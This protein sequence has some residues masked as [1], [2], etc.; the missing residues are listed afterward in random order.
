VSAGT[1]APVFIVGT[2]RSGTTLTAKILGRHSRLF[3]PGETHFFDDVYARASELGDPAGQ[4]ARLAIA[5]RLHTIYDRFYE[6]EDQQRIARLFPTV[7]DLAAALEGCTGYGAV[8]ERFMR[9]QMQA[10]GRQ[11]WGNNAPRDL[12]SVRD[13][14]TFFPDAR[15]VICVRDVR[16]FL[17]SYQGK[18]KVTG[19]AHVERLKKL[20]H[21]VVTSYL[22]KSS[23]QQLPLL[24]TLVPADERI[25]VRYEDLVTEP[26]RTVRNICAVIGEEFEPGMLEIEGHNSSSAAQTSGIFSS[27]VERW[28]TALSPEEIAIGQ[29]IAGRMLEGLGYATMPVRVHRA[30]WLALWLGTPFALVRALKANRDMHGPL[31]PYL[32]RRVG[33]LLGMH[34]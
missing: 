28:K 26:E 14:R 18:W 23:M 31:L 17:Y 19:A 1:T 13:I 25:I 32:F 27:S 30:R 33:S 34:R 8:L 29:S 2:P 11:R 7:Q 9:L 5:R 21:P 12:F 22:W 24:E 3:M 10:A 6:P 16:A 4:S 20:Y 15:L